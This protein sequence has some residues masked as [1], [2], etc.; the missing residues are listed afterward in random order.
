MKVVCIHQ[1]DFA[2]YLGFFHR[3]LFADHFV[4][5]DDVQFLRRGWHHR[6]Q[7]LTEGGPKWL[8]LR[9]NK[10]PLHRLINC[11]H[12]ESGEWIDEHLELIKKSYYH[13]PGFHYFY[14]TIEELYRS[15]K[16]SLVDF[17]LSF[18]E[19]ACD[20]LKIKIKKSFSSSY[21]LVS[22]KSERLIELVNK[23]GGTH[24]VTGLGSKAYLEEEKFNQ[25]GLKVIWKKFNHPK[26]EQ[27]NHSF[28]PNM[29][30]IDFI[31]NNG[32][33]SSKILH[34]CKI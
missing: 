21:N 14:P 23:V 13:T 3:L 5:L 27:S 6:D 12:I 19:W 15:K 10:G 28:F 17:N 4:I 29:S 18:I 31:M 34:A 16:K 9:V 30:F 32:Y 8:T 11:V 20:I 25:K 2:P 22:T 7:I 26:Y 24:Y 33:K 1:P